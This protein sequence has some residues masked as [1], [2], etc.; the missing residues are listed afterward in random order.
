MWSARWKLVSLWFSQTARVTADNALRFFVCLEYASYSDA[1]KNSAWY[2]VTA[3]FTLPAVF[4]APFNGAI[5]NSLPKS[6]VLTGSAFMGLA[7]MGVFALVQDHWLLCWTL[8][9]TVSAIYGPTRYAMLPAAAQDSHWPLT[10][11]NGFIEGGTFAAIIVGMILILGFDLQTSF[12]AILVILLLNGFGFLAALPVWFPSDVRRDDAPF[13]AVR[14]FFTDFRTIWNEREAR[15]CL[16]GLSGKR[17]LVI[18]MSGAMLA[19]MFVGTG[20]SLKEIGHIA[21]WVAA[22]VAVGSLMAGLQKHPRRVLGMVPVGATGFA[23]GMAY[24]ATGDS[25]NE[26]FCALVGIMAGLINVPLASTYQAAVPADA[27]GNGMAVRNLTDYVCA[28]IFGVGL[29]LLGRYADFSGPMQLWLIAGIASIGAVAAWWI[30][31]REVTEQLIEFG[32]AI[33][34]RFRVGGPGVEKF[35]LQGPVIVVAN[36]SAWMDP[37]WL[38]KVLPRTMIPMMTSVFFDHWLL[39]WM[40]I[41][42]ADAIRV[43]ASGFRRD[44]PELQKAIAALDAGKCLVLFPEGRLRRSEEQPLKL[45]G[46]GIW[47]ILKERPDTQVVVCWMEGGWGSY[48]SYFKGPPTK[49]KRFDIARP[50]DIAVGEPHKLDAEILADHRKTRQYLMEQCGQ[51]RQHLGLEPIVVK[52]AETESGEGT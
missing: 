22:G 9:A 49:N 38:A 21:A 48:F 34:Y 33:M 20:P 39:R 29:F 28:T 3:L 13:Q 41:Y 50:L 6:H 27:R 19:I 44:V 2:L 43:E 5:C 14:G 52:Q 15:I 7:V 37:M 4:L 42:L 45:F 24:A 11:I 47:H 8:I 26:W 31:R 46:Q 36:H 10:R 25:P 16:V 18:G 35:P 17:G 32:F 12:T 51:M 30:F 40:M 23:I 1:H